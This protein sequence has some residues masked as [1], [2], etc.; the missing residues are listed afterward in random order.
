MTKTIQTLK[1]VFKR[2][3]TPKTFYK[4]TNTHYLPTNTQNHQ[5]LA[6]TNHNQPQQLQLATASHN[7]PQ[8]ATTNH[9]SHNQPHLP[10]PATNSHNQPQPA[11]STENIELLAGLTASLMILFRLSM[12]RSHASTRSLCSSMER[13]LSAPDCCNLNCCSFEI[14]RSLLLSFISSCRSSII[15]LK[16]RTSS[17]FSSNSFALTSSRF[18]TLEGRGGGEGLWERLWR[19][20][21]VMG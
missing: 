11:T 18:I 10:Q 4:L 9:T 8:T 16:P 13:L 20:M 21:K 12:S 17:C 5:R 1:T 15:P 14:S 3:K 7:Q 6:T 19:E 2:S